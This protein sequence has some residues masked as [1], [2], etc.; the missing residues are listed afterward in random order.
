[1]PF[2]LT[3]SESGISQPICYQIEM[4][5]DEPLPAGRHQ[6]HNL[7]AVLNARAF[8][9]IKRLPVPVRHLRYEIGTTHACL[10]VVMDSRARASCQTF[11]GNVAPWH[12]ATVGFPNEGMM[13]AASQ[14][15]QQSLRSPEQRLLEL[16]PVAQKA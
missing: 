10:P 3:P 16:C 7:S 8:A 5:L 15:G 4:T 1:M 13:K 12:W 9:G 14:G 11:A 6:R 2:A